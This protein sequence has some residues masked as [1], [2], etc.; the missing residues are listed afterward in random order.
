MVPKPAVR[1][2]S[3]E[4]GR[5]TSYLVGQRHQGEGPEISA[6]KSS[7][8]GEWELGFKDLGVSIGTGAGVPCR[9]GWGWGCVWVGGHRHLPHPG[10]I[11]LVIRCTN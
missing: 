7:S 8:G 11:L 5:K 2:A 9:G 4:F 10:L 1:G 6:F 3:W